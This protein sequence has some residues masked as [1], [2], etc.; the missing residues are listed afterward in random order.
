M[1][2]RLDE[3]WTTKLRELPESSMSCQRVDVC[4]RDGLQVRSV[5]VFNAE[6]IEWL[7]DRATDPPCD[8]A[9]ISVAED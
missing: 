5:F 1:R 7:D 8:L 4:L 3:L 2:L 6:W 9:A